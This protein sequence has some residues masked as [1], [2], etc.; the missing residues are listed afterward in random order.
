[1]ISS[2][3]LSTAEEGQT[4]SVDESSKGTTTANEL[5]PVHPRATASNEDDAPSGATS[6]A[7]SC[8]GTVFDSTD[9]SLILGA[10]R[11]LFAALNNSW[12]LAIA[13]IGLMSVG[14][15]DNRATHGGVCVLSLGITSAI[16]AHGMH[17]R[18]C[19]QIRFTEGLL[20]FSESMIW[21]TVIA[22]WA[23]VALGMELYFGILHPYLDREK[24][25]TIVGNT[26]NNRGL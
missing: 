13:G 4:V 12:L 21:S 19:K 15:N 3:N 8:G 25:V 5:L 1:M 23:V 18:R 24:A 20:P 9:A 7:I 10:E 14:S 17:I 6:G 11:T 26:T 2:T 16:V 22:A